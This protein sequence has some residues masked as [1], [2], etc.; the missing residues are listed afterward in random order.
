MNMLPDWERWYPNC[1]PIGHLLRTE[2]SKRWVRFHSLPDSKQYPETE[3][4]YAEVLQRHNQI[5]SKLARSDKAVVLVTTG[6]S[7]TEV[8]MRSYTEVLELDRHAVPWRTVAMHRID[9]EFS[10]L[11]YWH[12]FTSHRI[13]SLG[14]FDPLFRLVADGEVANILIVATDCRWVLHPYD[15]GMDVIAES[16]GFRNDLKAGFSAWLSERRDGL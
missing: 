13:W 11:N 4:E 14:Q 5:L 16:R 10:D 7:E 3:T 12:F 8:P 15:G 6:Y 9:Q 1:E 2:F